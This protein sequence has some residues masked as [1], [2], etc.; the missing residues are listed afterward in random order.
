MLF[1]QNT[2]WLRAVVDN[3]LTDAFQDAWA[4]LVNATEGN[5]GSINHDV[6]PN[7]LV[8]FKIAKSQFYGTLRI[9]NIDN[10]VGSVNISI[11]FEPTNDSIIEINYYNATGQVTS[12]DKYIID[13]N[14]NTINLNSGDKLIVLS[15]STKRV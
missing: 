1:K 11:P 7:R 4:N 6:L 2:S 10:V 8:V 15:G 5:W 14:T 12:I 13:S 3:Q 9:P